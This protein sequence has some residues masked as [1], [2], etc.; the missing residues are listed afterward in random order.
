MRFLWPPF[1]FI[2]CFRGSTLIYFVWPKPLRSYRLLC[3]EIWKNECLLRLGEWLG[4]QGSSDREL[5]EGM[6][7]RSGHLKNLKRAKRI[8]YRGKK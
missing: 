3:I 1:Y 6:R 2:V 7:W 4:L 5:W 8:F